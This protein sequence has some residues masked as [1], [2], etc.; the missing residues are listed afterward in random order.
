MPAHLGSVSPGLM[1][2]ARARGETPPDVMISG[3][4]HGV[5]RRLSIIHKGVRPPMHHLVRLV[6][7]H[8]VDYMVFTLPVIA[9]GRSPPL[10]SSIRFEVAR[11]AR[12]RSEPSLDVMIG[13]PRRRAVCR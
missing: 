1:P 11:C 7:L 4:R 6:V 2:I 13:G 9:E 5:G 10:H 8:I 12:A 3:P